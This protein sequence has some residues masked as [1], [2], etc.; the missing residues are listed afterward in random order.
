MISRLTSAENEMQRSVVR[1]EPFPSWPVY[2]EECERAVLEVLRQGQGNYWSGPQGRKFQKAFADYLGVGHAISVANGTCALHTA[3]AACGIAPGDEVITSAYSFIASS[4]SVLNQGAVP[5]FAD[6][7]PV[8]HC[9]DPA[10]IEAKITPRTKAVICVHLYGHACDMDAIMA[11]ADRHGL[12]VI[13]DCAQ[14]HGG[15]YRGRKLG[16]IGHAGAF[17]FCQEKI[18]STG[19]EGGM[20]TTNDAELANRAS[21]IRD[22]GFDEQE[23]QQL[24]A[25]GSLYQYFHHRMGYNFRLTNLQ[26]ALGLVL[27]E[28]LDDFVAQRQRNAMELDRLLA[29]CEFCTL[30]HNSDNIR[31]AYYQYTLML[32]LDR[33]SIDRDDFVKEMQAEG[34][35]AGLG[36]TPENYLEEVFTLRAGFGRSGFPFDYP[37]YAGQLQKYRP[38]LCP[39][40]HQIGQQTVKLKV[41]PTCGLK[42]MQDTAVAIK[43][44]CERHRR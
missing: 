14:A 21:M 7:D 18:I 13:E 29:D 3:L 33:L 32:K 16:G 25:Q 24:K 41:H 35:P 39:V 4:T 10:D 1:T 15:E 31:H 43:R 26:A 22:H 44:V 30:P 27:L 19:G 17:S 38:G 9:I 36:N 12:F 8:T 37:A 6:V 23:R 28:R 2:D 40:A 34:I 20:V 11:L 5:V 42:E